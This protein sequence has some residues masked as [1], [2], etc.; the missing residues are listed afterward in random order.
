MP[1]EDLLSD[2]AVIHILTMG[3]L[4][5]FGGIDQR[6]TTHFR[7]PSKQSP[8]YFENYQFKARPLPHYFR[9]D[10]SRIYVIDNYLARLRRCRHL[11][12]KLLDSV[13]L[14]QLGNVISLARKSL[15]SREAREI[16]MLNL[17][18]YWPCWLYFYPL[19]LQISFLLFALEIL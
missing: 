8:E 3:F 19:M 18:T 15:V 1:T 16:S 2:P 14:H 11:I 7:G 12:G 17:L 13:H 5:T 9:D 10:P 6:A 4:T